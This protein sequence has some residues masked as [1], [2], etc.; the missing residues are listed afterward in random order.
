MLNIRCSIK[1]KVYKSA[2]HDYR[3]GMRND[4]KLKYYS[5]DHKNIFHSKNLFS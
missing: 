1:N 5:L 4:V 3:R 2:T